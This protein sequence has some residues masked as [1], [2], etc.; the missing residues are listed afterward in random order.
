[1]ITNLRTMFLNNGYPMY[2]FRNVLQSF[3]TKKH[4]PPEAVEDEQPEDDRCIVVLKIPYLGQFSRNFAKTLRL[5]IENKFNV[6]VQVVY[7]SFKVGS[8]FSLKSATPYFYRSNV[9][10]HFK[11]LRDVSNPASYVGQTSRHLDIRI[12][13][14]F[15]KKRGETAVFRHVST[16]TV[17]QNCNPRDTFTI[18]KNCRSAYES[19]V[20]EAL[21]I[22][23]LHPSLNKQL[24][25]NQGAAFL[26]KVFRYLPLS[27]SYL[28]ISVVVVLC[29]MA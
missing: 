6:K 27:P 20:H 15:T 29:S 5:L 14:H 8:Y 13:E 25:V 24:G 12:D 1:M 28:I 16:C 17:C 26:L 3:L 21:A 4:S 23:K 18:V 19:E 22:R 11:C 2:V 7:Q 10:Y 9:V